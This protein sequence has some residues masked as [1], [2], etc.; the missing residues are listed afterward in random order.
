VT[1]EYLKIHA[2]FRLTPSAHD[3]ANGAYK[4]LYALEGR[5]NTFWTGATWSEHCRIAR[6]FG[7][8]ALSL[9]PKM[10]AALRAR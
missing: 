7:G 8:G 5:R 6:R 10:E 9:L 4:D 3:V 2:P 1:F